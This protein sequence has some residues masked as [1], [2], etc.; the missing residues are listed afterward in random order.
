[1][2]Q[3]PKHL[4]SDLTATQTLVEAD[5]LN[6]VSVTNQNIQRGGSVVFII[7]EHVVG[8]NTSRL[9]SWLV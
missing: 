5:T 9:D 2:K 1:M 6:V 4:E 7:R 8:L 3:I